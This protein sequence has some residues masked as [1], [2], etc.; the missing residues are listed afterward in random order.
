MKAVQVVIT[1]DIPAITLEEYARR[2]GQGLD[3]VR[4]QAKMGKIPTLQGHRKGKVYVNLVAM[5]KTCYE[6]AGWD[7]KA[8]DVEYSL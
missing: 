4:Q 1:L 3:R 7:M 8:P 5:Y 6:A 2:S